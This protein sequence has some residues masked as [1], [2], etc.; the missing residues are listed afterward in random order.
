MRDG[1]NLSNQKQIRP[2]VR[3]SEIV[4][5]PSLNA[6]IRFP[7]DLPVTKC[8]LD[9]LSIPL[10]N[11]AFI[12]DNRQKEERLELDQISSFDDQQAGQKNQPQRH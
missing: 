8:R 3:A 4:N 6:Y 9:Y 2:L 11:P 5:L 1:V 10:S 7:G 12:Q